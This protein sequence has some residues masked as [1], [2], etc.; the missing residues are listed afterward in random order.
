MF[1]GNESLVQRPRDI[2]MPHILKQ[3]AAQMKQG[4]S[5]MPSD[6]VKVGGWVLTKAAKNESDTS[7][8]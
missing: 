5:H 4:R 2:R 8:Y 6:T 7:P 3:F 1:G